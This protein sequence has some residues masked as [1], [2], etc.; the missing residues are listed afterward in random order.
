MER[1]QFEKELKNKMD[2]REIM[3]S[4]KAWDRLDAMLAVAEQ[5]KPKRSFGWLYIAAGIV[6][7]LFIATIFFSQTEEV[8]DKGIQNQVVFES[9]VDKTDKKAQEQIIIRATDSEAIASAASTNSK[10]NHQSKSNPINHNQN[11]Q[12][13][14]AINAS[15]GNEKLI[16]S[17]SNQSTNFASN[18]VKEELATGNQKTEQPV[19][20]AKVDE[21]LA[22]VAQTPGAKPKTSVKVNAK[23][24]LSEVDHQVNLSFREK[25]LRRAGEVAEAVV[26]RNN[27]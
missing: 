19:T 8:V 23:N 15:P 10:Y 7:F 5:E 9:P 17:N 27:D 12:T 6:G 26:N 2:A 18:Q 11:I 22:S 16:A 20:A 13:V 25:M 1:N 3:P 24:L 21:L 4:D 14:E